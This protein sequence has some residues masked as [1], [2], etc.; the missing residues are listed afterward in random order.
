[1]DERWGAAEIL[2]LADRTLIERFSKRSEEIDQWLNTVAA[3]ATRAPKEYAES[4][5]SVYQRWAA[6][7][8][9]QGWASASSPRSARV[10]GA[11]QPAGQSWARR[12]TPWPARTG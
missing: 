10:D 3:V 1:V 2:G 6:E 8:A 5:A 9:E 11:V 12:W 7:L 4:E